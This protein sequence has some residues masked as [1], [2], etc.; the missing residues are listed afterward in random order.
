MATTPPRVS[1]A[2]VDPQFL[3]RWSPRAFS[4]EPLADPDILALLE[5][6]RWAPSSFNEQPWLLVFAHQ[7]EDLRKFRPLMLDQNR[8]WADQAPLLVVIFARRHFSHNGQPNRHYM[9]DAGAAWM[10]LALQARKLGLYAHAMAGFHQD[11]AYEILHVPADRYEAIC[12]VAVGRH[13][14]VGRLPPAL[15]AREAP[16]PRKPL[17]EFAY[18][19]VYRPQ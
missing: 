11:Q 16:G 17:S 14:D 12:V 4:P 5:A 9:F 7:E 15:A 8:Q 18:E 2:A 6:A 3:D 13:G 1:E 10:S 19:G